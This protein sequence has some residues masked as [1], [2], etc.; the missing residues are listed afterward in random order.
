M[1]DEH[2][3]FIKFE[4]DGMPYLVCECGWDDRGDEGWSD[5][6]DDAPEA[7]LLLDVEAVAH[8]L[9]RAGWFRGVEAEDRARREA[10]RIVLAATTGDRYD[11]DDEY[12]TAEQYAA[13]ARL[14]GAS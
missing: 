12:L 6:L 9:L 14:D 7:R 5:H 2:F 10:V 1:T 11:L 8:H 13:I 3:P 4:R